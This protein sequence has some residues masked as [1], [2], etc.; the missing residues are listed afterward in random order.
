MTSTLPWDLAPEI[1]AEFTLA[2]G[3]AQMDWTDPGQ[4]LAITEAAKGLPLYENRTSVRLGSFRRVARKD[5][6]PLDAE[7]IPLPQQPRQV[8]FWN[9]IQLK[10]V[11]AP[12]TP[13]RPGKALPFTL[14][15]QATAPLTVDLTT[16][17]HLLDD[18]GQVVAQLDWS[19]QDVLGYLPTSAWQP[20]HPVVDRQTLQL[21]EELAPGQYRL[22]VG[23]Y[24]GPT[25]ERLPITGSDSLNG[26]M[27]GDVV[28]VGSV[29]VQ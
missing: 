2:V 23:W 13:L 17:A 15:W 24:Y 8:Q 6:E 20:Q 4:R 12:T 9:V 22:V 21:P 29:I 5:Y 26:Q 7:T 14:H 27:E 16:F 11:E 10:G 3:V 28:Q 18:Q 25:G 19:P 1:G